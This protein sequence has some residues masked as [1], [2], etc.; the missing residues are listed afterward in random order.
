MSVH[1]DLSGMDRNL[2][3]EAVRVTEAAALSASLLMGRGDEKLADQAAV[4]AMRQALNTLYIDGTVVIGEGERD[5]APMLY[6]GEKVGAGIGR[7]PKVDIA[8][9]P[10]EGTTICATGGPN[11]LAVIAMAD[12]G[13]FLNAPDVYMDKIAVGSGLPEGVVDL[14]ETPANNLKALAKAKGTEV[15]ELLVCILNRPRHAELIARVREAGARIM[16]IN[17]GDVS[18]VIATSQAGT[19]VDMYVGSGGAPEGVLAAAALRCIGGQF[20][21]RLLFRN[22]D[23]KARA[24]R[25]GV[26]DLN[27]KY[28]LTELASG[29][30]M[31]AA[32]GV[33]DGAML[34]GVRRYPGGAVTHSVI[35]RSK[36]GTVRYVEAHHNLQRKPAIK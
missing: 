26:K 33:T 17:D 6:I 35:M 24:A 16:L 19:G 25:W 18:G 8:L 5:E 9:D 31:F 11:S 10:L 2:A 15:Q 23:E 4:D 32:T 13:G 21:G 27:K 34:R 12:E 22:D 3:L 20:Q 29:N 36:S 14:D 7:G 30:V 1:V 28:S